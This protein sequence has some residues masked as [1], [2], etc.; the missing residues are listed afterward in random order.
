MFLQTQSFTHCDRDKMTT[1]L[2]TSFSNIFSWMKICKFRLIFHQLLLMRAQL[3]IRKRWFRQ[4]LGTEQAI[5]IIWTSDDIFFSDTY[6]SLGFDELIYLSLISQWKPL[7]FNKNVYGIEFFGVLLTIRQ[8]RF[9]LWHQGD[10]KPMLTV[11]RRKKDSLIDVTK[12]CTIVAFRV[13]TVQS[14]K[15]TL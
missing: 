5:A 3:T 1:I 10:N 9:M 12:H 8:H 15:W 4:G 7:N 14:C 11:H 6:P 2:P 13:D